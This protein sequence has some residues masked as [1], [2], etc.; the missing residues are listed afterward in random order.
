MCMCDDK[1]SI[2]YRIFLCPARKQFV[3]GSPLWESHSLQVVQTPW[4]V[5]PLWLALNA[6]API[7]PW[8]FLSVNAQVEVV[9][10]GKGDAPTTF[11]LCTVLMSSL[12]WVYVCAQYIHVCACVFVCVCVCVC[13]CVRACTHMCACIVMCAYRITNFILPRQFDL[14]EL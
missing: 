10:L 2:A 3:A 12:R 7:A 9:V 1:V 8:F 5:S 4:S 11:S 13:V 14:L 6:S